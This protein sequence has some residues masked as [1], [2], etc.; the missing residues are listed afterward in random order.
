MA[1]FSV[2]VTK[3]QAATMSLHAGAGNDGGI[4]EGTASP[5][6][7][8]TIELRIDQTTTVMT[9]RDIMLALDKFKLYFM[10]L[11][12]TGV[13]AGGQGIPLQP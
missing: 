13:A 2:S 5:T 9:R 6:A 10:S 4:T 12:E 8:S 3:G 11:G 1:D 7:A